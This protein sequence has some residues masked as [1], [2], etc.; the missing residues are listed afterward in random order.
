MRTQPNSYRT[1]QVRVAAA[2]YSA[3]D[4]DDL[5]EI[6]IKL[7]K[8]PRYDSRAIKQYIKNITFDVSET[9]R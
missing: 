2:L 5:L 6:S 8:D 4:K 1:Q 9:F 3:K 7:I